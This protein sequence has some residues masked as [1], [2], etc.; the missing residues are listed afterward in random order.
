M[1][2]P[3]AQEA[4]GDLGTD[5]RVVYQDP[6][7]ILLCARWQTIRGTIKSTPARLVPPGAHRKGDSHG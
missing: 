2:E 5:P 4:W 7:V 6:D 1:S 3:T